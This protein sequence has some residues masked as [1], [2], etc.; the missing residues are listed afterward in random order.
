VVQPDSVVVRKEMLGNEGSG[1]N[2]GWE[3]TN[4]LFLSVAKMAWIVYETENCFVAS[5]LFRL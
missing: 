1:L 2:T 3:L 5:P 4:L